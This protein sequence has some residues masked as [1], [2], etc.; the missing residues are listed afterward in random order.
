MTCIGFPRISTA[1]SYFSSWILCRLKQENGHREYMSVYQKT[2]LGL[3]L[4]P[5]I[6]QL[7]NIQK[8]L[9]KSWEI[10]PGYT[11]GHFGSLRDAEQKK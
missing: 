5:L 2:Y 9:E 7:H 6:I 1:S 4:K 11:L 3:S 8:F 10:I